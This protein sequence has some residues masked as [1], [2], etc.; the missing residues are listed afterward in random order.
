MME[1]YFR[2]LLF[3]VEERERKMNNKNLNSKNVKKSNCFAPTEEGNNGKK[4]T[5]LQ[6]Q[7]KKNA[8]P[9]PRRAEK[10]RTSNIE[11]QATD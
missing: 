6:R 8:A 7:E 3:Q 10:R 2:W 9:Q 5:Q 4:R 11:R 1:I